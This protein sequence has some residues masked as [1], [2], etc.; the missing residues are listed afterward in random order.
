MT[1]AQKQRRKAY[2]RVLIF[3]TLAIALYATVFTNADLVMKYFTKGGFYTVLPVA[4]VFVFSYIHG[5]FASNVWTALGICA[6]DKCLKT[7]EKSKTKT[8]AK[9]PRARATL[10]A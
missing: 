4:T 1:A 7:A 5:S 6:S 10:H 8:K 2:P 3:G 9:R